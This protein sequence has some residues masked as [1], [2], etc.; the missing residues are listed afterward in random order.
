MKD[1]EI[2]TKNKVG[3]YGIYNL[4]KEILFRD[5]VPLNEHFLALKTKYQNE[6]G[7]FEQFIY[8]LNQLKL[9]NYRK[10]LKTFKKRIRE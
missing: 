10:K 9:R 8:V 1:K 4:N 6:K 5:G 2:D 3:G 7:K